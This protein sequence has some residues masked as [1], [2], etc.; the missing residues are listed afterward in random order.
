MQ[1]VVGAGVE[2]REQQPAGARLQGHG[3]DDRL[4]A[5]GDRRVFGFGKL[6]GRGQ[7]DDPLLYGRRNDVVAPMNPPSAADFVVRRERGSFRRSLVVVTFSGADD[8]WLARS[9]ERDA[10][11]DRFSAARSPRPAAVPKP[12]E[13][14][15]P[16]GASHALRKLF[17]SRS[18]RSKVPDTSIDKDKGEGEVKENDVAATPP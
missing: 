17:I 16:G 15:R 13:R 10:R 4:P 9:P 14:T 12:A 8:R 5:Q 7:I 18:S 11:D 2:R 6:Q 1:V 3:L